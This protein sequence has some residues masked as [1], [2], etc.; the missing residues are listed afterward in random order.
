MLGINIYILNSIYFSFG[1]FAF[2]Y[3]ASSCSEDRASSII[4]QAI[5]AHGGMTAFENLN[6]VSLEKEIYFFNEEG[7][8][9]SSD[10]R[11]QE[12]WLG[13]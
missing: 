6:F 10:L 3:L 12:F 5:S 7:D 8:T 4:S 11:K 9:V 13:A 1:L 2:L